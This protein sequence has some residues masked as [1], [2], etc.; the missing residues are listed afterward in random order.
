MLLTPHN[1]IG[2]AIAH[3]TGSPILAAPICFVAHFVCDKI[4]HWDFFS[5]TENDDGS[6]TKGWRFFAFV[7]DFGL[8][9]SIGWFFFYRGAFLQ[10]DLFGAITLLS[11]AFFSNLPDAM[12][13]PYI[14]HMDIYKKS[15]FLEKFTN[16]QKNAQ[17]QA[18]P[19]IGITIQLILSL[20]SAILLLG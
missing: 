17:T 11:G 8:A 12:E 13:S 6:R 1:F 19:I 10:N 5:G 15:K 2:M 16:L 7:A 18:Q 4:P 9:L 20:F 14:F 3:F